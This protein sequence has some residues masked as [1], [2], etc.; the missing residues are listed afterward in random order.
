MYSLL[1]VRKTNTTDYHP[2]TDGLLVEQFNCT[3]TNM[4]A[5]KVKKKNGRE[6]DVQL[7]CVL[8]AYHT[9][10][11]KSTGESPFFL[12][13]RRD[14][15]LPMTDMLTGFYPSRWKDRGGL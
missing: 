11:H 1:K 12:M 14:P 6:W 2:Q 8:F 7:P 10:P 3:L 4:L 15:V 9:S 13:Y 5:K